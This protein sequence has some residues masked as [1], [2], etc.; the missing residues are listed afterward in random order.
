MNTERK[1][2]ETIDE[3]IAAFPPDIQKKLEGL[4]KTIQESAPTAKE[5]NSYGMPTFK[6]KRNLVHFAVHKAHIGFYPGGP[7]A[8]NAFEKELNEY[9]TSKGAIR[10]P[11]DRPIPLDI[12]GRI[13]KFRV[14]EE[15]QKIKG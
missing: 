8:V 10:F 2:S 13:V 5:T 6:L 11:L 1:R 15:E 7:S 9:K 3:Y 14:A 4:R 12:V